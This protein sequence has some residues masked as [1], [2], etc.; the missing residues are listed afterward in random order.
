MGARQQTAD[1]C[2]QPLAHEASDSS[3][4]CCGNSGLSRA[5]AAVPSRYPAVPNDGRALTGMA[6]RRWG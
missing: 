4:A 6:L 5:A 3:P 2:L 1:S